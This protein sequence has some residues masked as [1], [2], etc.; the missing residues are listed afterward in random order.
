MP[1]I[2]KY[3]IK[4]IYPLIGLRIVGLFF[5]FL[6]MACSTAPAIEQGEEVKYFGIMSCDD[7]SYIILGLECPQPPLSWTQGFG[8]YKCE[9]NQLY[10]PQK[11]GFNDDF[12]IDVNAMIKPKRY[13]EVHYKEG[14]LK[15]AYEFK[16][17]QVQLDKKS[18]DSFSFKEGGTYAIEQK[19]EYDSNGRETIRIS[20]PDNLPNTWPPGICKTTYGKQIIEERCVLKERNSKSLWT[21]IYIDNLLAKKSLYGGEKEELWEYTIYDHKNQKKKIFNGKHELEDESILNYSVD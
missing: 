9:G 12:I 14:K 10:Y 1:M 6:Q 17:V 16:K 7:P 5:T 20:N 15:Y 19:Y 3:L 18:S 4:N 11:C 8:P 2:K 13:Y 21:K